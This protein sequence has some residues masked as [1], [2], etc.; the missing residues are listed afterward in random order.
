[1]EETIPDKLYFKIGEVSKLAGVETHVLRYWESEFNIVKPSRTRAKQRLY[2]K[3]D[4]GLILA[5][6]KLLYQDK[7]TIEGA[8]NILK[9]LRGPSVRQFS[10]DSL[11]NRQP[12]IISQL[13][14]DLKDIKNILG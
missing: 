5:I 6:K 9:E 1:M 11:K 10:S 2:S 4:L 7:F 13:K 3:E 12:N 8:K 14:K